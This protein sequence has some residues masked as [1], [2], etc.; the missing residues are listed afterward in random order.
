MKQI[1][2]HWFKKSVLLLEYLLICCLW[3]MPLAHSHPDSQSV[4]YTD[5]IPKYRANTTNFI[6]PKIEYTEKE[7]IL[8][9]LYVSDKDN[10]V[11]RFYGSEREF[12]WRL[13]N[14]I[15]AE[16]SS[17][18]TVT[19]LAEINNVRVN[20]EL[21][22]EILKDRSNTDINANKGDIVSCEIHFELMPAAIRSV[23]LL[24]GDCIQKD[25]FVFR[26]N[27][28][29]ILIKP[30][31]SDQLGSQRQM[32][33][34]VKRF[35]AEIGYVRYPDIMTATTLAQ[36]EALDA[37]DQNTAP[38]IATPFEKH[39]API[40]YMPQ[41]LLEIDDLECN[42]RVILTD[43]HFQESK[44][45]FVS[46]P[47]A[48]ETLEILIEYMTFNPKAKVIL[49]GHTD[50]FGNAFNNLEISKQ[51]VSTVKKAIESKGIDESRIITIHHGGSQALPRYKN[52]GAMNR[53]VE[54]EVMC[55]DPG[56][57]EKK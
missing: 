24:G 11:I 49:H 56:I 7:I 32:E 36:Q 42:K 53:R 16:H 30:A 1:Y 50:I 31:D 41:T 39:L 8:H 47:K 55:A 5:F 2:F 10:D 19:R 33:E 52:G 27:C 44:P 51:H 57:A 3:Q 9:F 22:R 15:R 18:H 46:R 43:V 35:Y 12:A 48:M 40:D 20:D 17:I 28:N 4:V 34:V 54:V 38:T 26:F 14:S 6:I 21:K 37:K 23:H 45:E 25:G 29:D 13:T